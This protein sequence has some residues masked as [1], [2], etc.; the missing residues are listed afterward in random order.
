[1]R[2][3]KIM[4]FEE[5]KRRETVKTAYSTV[6]IISIFTF[7][8]RLIYF[9]PVRALNESGASDI[10]KIAISLLC[11]AAAVFIPFAIYGK[12]REIKF[13]SFFQ[14]TPQKKKTAGISF[15][16]GLFLFSL[17]AATRLPLNEFLQYLSE[18]GFVFHETYPSLQNSV[19]GQLFYLFAVPLI[20]AAAVEISLRGFALGA[21]KNTSNWFPVL[22]TAFLNIFL[23]PSWSDLPM[24]IISGFVLSWLYVK[25]KSLLSVFLCSFAYRFIGALLT[26]L[27]FN[28]DLSGYITALGVVGGVVALLSLAIIILVY[29]LTLGK[30]PKDA[31]SKKE[32]IKA[33][34]GSSVLYMLIFVSLVQT[35]CFYVN[36]PEEDEEQTTAVY[37]AENNNK[38]AT[39]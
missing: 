39:L 3:E 13:S 34:F 17:S 9:Y 19:S 6:L 20:T 25:T 2:N 8:I 26:V 4:T 18:N 27:S 12:I 24:T 37:I 14:K 33:I 5:E 38:E 30:K 22:V 23:F 16:S 28:M 31:F 11:S 21:I 10:L 36:K 15:F 32:G 29:K 35:F 7:V 1:M